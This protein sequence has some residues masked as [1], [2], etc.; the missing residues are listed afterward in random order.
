MHNALRAI[1]AGLAQAARMSF[2]R[3]HAR[4]GKTRRRRLYVEARKPRLIY[5]PTCRVNGL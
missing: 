3:S 4:E 5:E 1:R 2:P